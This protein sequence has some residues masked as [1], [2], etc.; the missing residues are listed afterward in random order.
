MI[1]A[2]CKLVK[3]QASFI[4]EPAQ[5]ATKLWPEIFSSDEVRAR[6]ERIL[7]DMEYV[8]PVVETGYVPSLLKV[9]Q[10]NRSGRGWRPRLVDDVHVSADRYENLV[11]I[12]CLLE[13]VS[14]DDILNDW[15]TVLPE[16]ME[17]WG[18]ER[19]QVRVVRLLLLLQ[20]LTCFPAIAISWSS[21]QW[22]HSM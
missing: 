14:P 12:R 2:F 20:W 7:R 10:K 15:H 18:V 13:G 22:I 21:N 4:P 3:R 5:A 6:K 19:G 11:Q 8:R 1:K 17:K 9:T 16:H